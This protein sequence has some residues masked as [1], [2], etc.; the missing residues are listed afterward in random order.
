MIERTAAA[1]SDRSPQR[2]LT[3]ILKSEKLVL[4]LEIYLT[5]LSPG[6]VL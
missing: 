4:E 1:L 5:L 6:S 3:N 2:N